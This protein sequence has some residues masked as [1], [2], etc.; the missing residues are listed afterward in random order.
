MIARHRVRMMVKDGDIDIARNY[1][2]P[3]LKRPTPIT[4]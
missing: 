2:Y 3:R 4:W 1:V